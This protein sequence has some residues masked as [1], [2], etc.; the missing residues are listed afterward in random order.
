[1]T[2]RTQHIIGLVEEMVIEA[3]ENGEVM[4]VRRV[5]R[6]LGITNSTA[7]LILKKGLNFHP[8]HPITIYHLIEDDPEVRIEFSRLFL[9]MEN[10]DEEFMDKIIWSDKSL[11][12]VNGHVNRHNTVYWSPSNPNIVLEQDK[13]GETVMVWAGMWNGGRIGSYFFNG[14]VNAESY[15]KLLNEYLWPEISAKVAR[16]RLWFQQDGAPA[17][18]SRIVPQWLDSHFPKRWIGR[19]SDMPWPPRSPDL[20]TADFFLWG[21]FKDKVYRR[22]PTNIA[23]LKQHIKEEF[24]KIPQGMIKNSCGSVIS[25]LKHCIEHNGAPIQITYRKSAKL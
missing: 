4:S 17:H 6:K 14:P 5:A 9:D 11:F 7:Y 3:T 2:A 19:Q 1:M 23:T 15:L 25:R 24:N 21:Y 12:S 13:L 22:Q 10:K 8:Y 16:D 18:F 20:T